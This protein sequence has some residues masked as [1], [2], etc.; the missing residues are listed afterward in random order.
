MD[1]LMLL[2]ELYWGSVSFVRRSAAFKKYQED[3]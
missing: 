2:F 1:R 3:K